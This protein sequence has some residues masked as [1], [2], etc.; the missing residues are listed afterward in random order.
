MLHPSL[1]PPLPS[2]ELHAAEVRDLLALGAAEVSRYQE[3]ARGDGLLGGEERVDGGGGIGR[4]GRWPCGMQGRSVVTDGPAVMLG[5]LWARRRPT[6]RWRCVAPSVVRLQG[7]RTGWP[8]ELGLADEVGPT[9]VLLRTGGDGARPSGDA[10]GARYAGQEI[11]LGRSAGR[12]GGGEEHDGI[13]SSW[14]SRVESLGGGKG[15]N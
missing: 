11:G 13:V 2:V 6:R 10:A 8:D 3:A 15:R 9:A 14:V 7:R 12:S 5:K 1:V 4:G